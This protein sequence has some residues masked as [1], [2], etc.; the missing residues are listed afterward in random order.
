M[1]ISYAEKWHKNDGA[2]IFDLSF[3]VF[4]QFA[5][6]NWKKNSRGGNLHKIKN[7]IFISKLLKNG[8]E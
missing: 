1:C 3:T 7:K 6:K 4:L 2:K 5:I 8:K